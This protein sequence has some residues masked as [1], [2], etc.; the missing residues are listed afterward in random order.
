M[1]GGLQ[2]YCIECTEARRQYRLKTG[3]VKPQ[4]YPLEE[5]LYRPPEHV[6]EKDVGLSAK[7][8]AEAWGVHYKTAELMRRNWWGSRD[9]TI[10]EITEW[11]EAQLYRWMEAQLS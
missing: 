8:L 1:S 7:Q 3:P 6:L 10:P 5:L 9:P 2:G 4:R 11:H